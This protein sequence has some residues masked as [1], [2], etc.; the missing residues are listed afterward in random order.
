MSVIDLKPH[1]IRTKCGQFSCNLNVFSWSD[2]T[3]V[4]MT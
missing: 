1:M 3:V 4:G 2:F